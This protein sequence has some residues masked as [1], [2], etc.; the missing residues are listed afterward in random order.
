MKTAIYMRQSLDRDRNQLAVNRQREDLLKLC[1]TKKGWDDPIEYCDDNISAKKG[2][3]RPAWDELCRDIRDGIIGRLAVWD[4]DRLRRTVR[5]GEDFI[6][7]ADEHH[8]KLANVGGDVDLSTAQGRMFFRMKGTI[9]SYE[10][11]HKSARQKRANKQRADAG[12]PWVTRPFGYTRK[13]IKDKDGKVI[14]AWLEIEEGEAEA[15]RKACHA[16]LNGATLWSIATDW[17][18]KGLKTSKGYLWEGSKVR[19]ALLRPSNAGLAV[20]DGEILDGVGLDVRHREIPE[21]GGLA[22]RDGEIPDGETPAPEPIIE[23]DTWEA[24]R[25]LLSDP[26]RFTGRSMA[27]KHLLSGLA[28]CGECGK[29][30]G[31]VARPTKTGG[32][33]VIYQCK[34]FGCMKIVR[35]LAKTDALVIDIITS[36]LADPE[37]ARKLAKPTVDTKALHEQIDTLR[38][39]ITATR[40]EYNEGLINARDRNARIER[41]TEKLSP[42]EDKLLGNHM[43][44][45]VKDL[46]GKPDAAERFEDLSLDRRRGV[47]DTLTTV[48]IHRQVKAGGQFEDEAITVD[49]K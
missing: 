10:I 44:R 27:R 35:D 48:T 45:D 24:V 22:V 12:R 33:R 15:I 5:D 11:E 46:A 19:L 18:K 34:N 37:A 47:I 31:T 36:R 2:S 38:K 40:E 28:Y 42:L 14:E 26:K 41:I 16:L 17:N 3:K 1:A 25:K 32:K 23:R 13:V 6:D 4:D 20:H 21:A 29:R 9:A 30:M 39:L 7:L 43:S 49:W 8:V